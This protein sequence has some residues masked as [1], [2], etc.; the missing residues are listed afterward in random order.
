MQKTKK[1]KVWNVQ[2]EWVEV[3][4]GWRRWDQVYQLVLSWSNNLIQTQ[5]ELI[6]SSQSDQV[7]EEAGHASSFL[8]T[9]VHL[10]TDQRPN[11]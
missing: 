10:P 4:D 1:L 11:D 6:A 7:R 5:T 8:C 2:R 9:G 3:G